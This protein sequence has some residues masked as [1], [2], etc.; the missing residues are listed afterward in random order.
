MNEYVGTSQIKSAAAA[1]ER[2]MSSPDTSLTNR[3]YEDILE[4]SALVKKVM[5]VATANNWSKSEVARRMEMPDGT[6]SQWYSGKYAGRLENQ[7]RI[8]GQWLAAV[9]ETAG[10]AATIPTSPSFILTKTASEVTETLA[11]AQMSSDFVVITIAAGMGKT[12]TCLN[13][14]ST[15]PHSHLV[16]VSPHTKTVHGLLVDIAA[17]LD[18]I[19]HNPAK[20]TRAIG[21]RLR[22]FG[23]GTLLIVDEA[24]NLVDDA[25]NQ[26]RHFVDVYKCGV[27]LVGNDEIY[28]RF[29]QGKGDGPSYAQIKRRIGKRLQRTKPYLEDIQAFIEAW[30]VTDPAC[31]KFLTGIGMKGG[32]LGQIDKTMKLA[33]LQAMGSKKP[34]ALEHIQAAWRN[35]DVEDM[36]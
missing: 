27:A 13:Y 33:M 17:E 28:G 34:L 36:A 19:I 10:I 11:W 26:L 12:A 6:F 15:R 25:I 16:T 21:D 5:T 20:L 23:G 7:N 35:R 22:R 2:P 31:I 3:T 14:C 30:N 29:R 9:E 1:W 4:W 24:Q 18:L 32:A 8:V